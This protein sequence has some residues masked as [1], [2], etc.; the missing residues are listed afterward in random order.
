MKVL[1]LLDELEDIIE[2]SSGFPLTGKILVDGSE[3]LEIIKE[4]RVELPD[5]IQQA[6]WIKEERQRILAEAQKE[7]EM[8][9]KEAKSNIESMIENDD[10]SVKARVKAEE[11]LRNADQSAKELKKNALE[12]VDNILGDL[13]S[14]I[15]QVQATYID[16][17]Y[18]MIRKNFD[19]M[20]AT[21]SANR[22]EIRGMM[23][24]S[25]QFDKVTLET[26]EA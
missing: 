9:M 8:M 25:Q 24:K 4:I 11:I 14:K 5:E 12:Y 22:N 18:S 20:D 21:I 16:E 7:S 10:L 19:H 17:M 15:E 2:N 13:Q 26:E 23:Y 6:Q 3:V 1:H